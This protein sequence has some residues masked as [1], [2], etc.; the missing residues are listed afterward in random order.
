MK[1]LAI[2]FKIFE[3]GVNAV[4]AF[5]SVIFMLMGIV[6]SIFTFFLS[7]GVLGIFAFIILCMLAL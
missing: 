6:T 2:P 1:I 5:F 3:F 4:G 7:F